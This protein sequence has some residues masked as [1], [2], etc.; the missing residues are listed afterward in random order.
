MS[1]PKPGLG[2][3]IVRTIVNHHPPLAQS[4]LQLV[5]SVSSHYAGTGQRREFS[6]LGLP[7]GSSGF[8]GPSSGSHYGS[9]SGN[10]GGLSGSGNGSGNSLGWVSLLPAWDDFG[11]DIVIPYRANRRHQKSA[12][13]SQASSTAPSA[14]SS[15]GSGSGSALGNRTTATAS[16]SHSKACSNGPSKRGLSTLSVP[17][18]DGLFSLPTQVLWNALDKS[19]LSFKNTNT[20][21]PFDQNINISIDLFVA[22]PSPPP[23]TLRTRSGEAHPALSPTPTSFDTS[24]APSQ[25]SSSFYTLGIPI[26]QTLEPPSHA[27]DPENSDTSVSSTNNLIF[28]LGAS[29]LAKERPAFSTQPRNTR[30][31]LPHRPRTFPLP[32]VAIPAPS[33]LKS[34]GVG[35]D[36][37]FARTD[38][39]CIADG[40][41]GW[42]RSGRGGADAGRWS[43]LLTHFCEAELNDWWEGKEDFLEPEKRNGSGRGSDWA[44][45]AWDNASGRASGGSDGESKR[46][47]RPLDPVEIMQRGYEK[48]LS[49]FTSEVS[50]A[51]AL[52]VCTWERTDSSKSTDRQHA[53]WQR[54]ITPPCPLLIWATA[55]Y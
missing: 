31:P 16:S 51:L 14:S 1:K 55:A 15:T 26:N 23:T 49:C 54:Y 20:P 21:A 12:S 36:A 7:A 8:V 38:G 32:Q 22:P 25:A 9:H 11:S 3:G 33:E 17:S 24:T 29:G 43:K 40:V 4:S 41:G 30:P 10:G 52:M 53:S 50:H 13:T 27:S 37:Y 42:A 6:S 2:K 34:V 19:P 18:P 46:V 45:S 44:A 28:H 5:P 35:E 47:R 48:C 39:M